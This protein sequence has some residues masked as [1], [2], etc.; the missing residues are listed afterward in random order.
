MYSVFVFNGVTSFSFLLGDRCFRFRCVCT[1]CCVFDGLEFICCRATTVVIIITIMGI[2]HNV[3]TR[4]G[5][6]L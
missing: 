6:N 3:S 4:L 1:L 5:A 2:L